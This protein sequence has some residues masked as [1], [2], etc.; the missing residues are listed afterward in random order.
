[1]SRNKKLY[2]ED[3]MYDD[4]DDDGYIPPTKS[5]TKPQPKSQPKSK[6]KSKQ[7]KSLQSIK[8]VLTPTPTSSSTTTKNIEETKYP[9]EVIT[10]KYINSVDKK[11]G[12]IKINEDDRKLNTEEKEVTNNKNKSLDQEDNRPDTIN[13]SVE[14]P[15]I[16][17][18]ITGHVD[19]GKSTLLGNM[20]FKLGNINQKVIHKFQKQSK[21]IGKGSFALAW[22]MDENQSEREHGVTIDIAERLT[23]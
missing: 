1:M 7:E 21:E 11:N 20:L 18:V 22:V 12:N 16:T 15:T 17:V 3:D 6:S 14:K 19:G 8:P 23:S 5:N 4:D 9:I 2:D 10:N 13:S